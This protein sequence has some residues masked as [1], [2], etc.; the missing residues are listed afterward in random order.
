M[1]LPC[2]CIHSK[3]DELHG[4]GNRVFN[5]LKKDPGGGSQKYRC[6]V[7]KTIKDG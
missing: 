2:N 4:K 3:Q 6:T 7:C 1:I 5:K